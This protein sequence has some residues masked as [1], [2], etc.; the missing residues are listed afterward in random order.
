[1]EFFEYSLLWIAA[2][3]VTTWITNAIAD[4]WIHIKLP[5]DKRA[6]FNQYKRE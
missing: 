5:F 4:E 3:F 2:Y 1:M 6:W